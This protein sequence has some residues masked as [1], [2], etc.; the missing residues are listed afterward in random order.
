MKLHQLV[1]EVTRQEAVNLVAKGSKNVVAVFEGESYFVDS[2]NIFDKDEV[3]FYYVDYQ[4]IDVIKLLDQ[5][6]CG[7]DDYIRVAYNLH[8]QEVFTSMKTTKYSI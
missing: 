4:Q 6:R 3:M 5:L 2:C 8:E 7:E 1:S